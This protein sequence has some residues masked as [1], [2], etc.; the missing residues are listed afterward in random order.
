MSSVT[1]TKSE[2]T[3]GNGQHEPVC[4]GDLLLLPVPHVASAKAEQIFDLLGGDV[5]CAAK[6][7]RFRTVGETDLVHLQERGR[8]TR[9]RKR[10]RQAERERERRDTERGEMVRRV[11]QMQDADSRRQSSRTCSLQP[12]CKSSQFRWQQSKSKHMPQLKR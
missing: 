10:G 3:F 5:L 6:H 1:R 2:S 7:E 12:A 11:A 8:E 4:G 9:S